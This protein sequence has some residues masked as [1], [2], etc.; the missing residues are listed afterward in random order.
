M[1]HQTKK[2]RISAIAAISENRVLGNKGKIPWHIPEDMKRFRRV[3]RGHPVIMGRKTYESIGKPLSDR[4]NIIVTRQEEYHPAGV[5][6]MP[7]V[8]KAI[9]YAQMHEDEEVFIIGGGQVYAAALPRTERLYLTVVKAE[10]AGDTYFPEYTE[11][12]KE[13]GRTYSSD[14]KYEYVFLTLE[15]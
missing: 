12:S 8:N 7:D 6:I 5:E 4:L 3:T 1:E 2:P 15:K 10:F 9:D 13:I 11:F 14:D